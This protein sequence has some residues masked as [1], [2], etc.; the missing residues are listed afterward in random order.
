MDKPTSK[1][2]EREKEARREA[3]LDAAARIFSLKSFHE[4]TLEEI[5]STAELAKG[6]L[7]NYFKDKQDIF[8][9]LL[10]RGHDEFLEA[11]DDQ[12]SSANTLGEFVG[13]VFD[14]ILRVMDKNKYME[15]MVLTAGT[16]L[17][18][19]GRDELIS[20]WRR[21]VEDATWL[22]ADSLS[23]IP[24]TAGVTGDERYAAAV[25]ILSSAHAVYHRQHPP[26]GVI[27]SGVGVDLYVTM[28]CRVLKT[29]KSV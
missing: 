3:I 15:R 21:A 2:K 27:P 29:E 18:E 20:N 26:V 10:Q 24:E 5:A 16:H 22:L 23:E 4:A 25:M 9:S 6:T 13:R 12:R 7:Y 14:T 11:L 28:I 8:A 19:T 1:R 17:T